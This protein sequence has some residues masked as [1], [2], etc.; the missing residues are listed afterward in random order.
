M[1]GMFDKKMVAILIFGLLALAFAS[2]KGLEA[3]W[4]REAAAKKVAVSTVSAEEQTAYLLATAKH[5]GSE[6]IRFVT[7]VVTPA[8]S[9]KV[10]AEEA[11]WNKLGFSLDK[12]SPVVPPASK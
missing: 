6:P 7:T 1:K 8:P 3:Q 10:S 12:G 5:V 2:Y 9:P 4:Q 11:K